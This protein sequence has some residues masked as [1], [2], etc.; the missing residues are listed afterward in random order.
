MKLQ[1]EQ[2]ARGTYQKPGTLTINPSRR[3]LAEEQTVKVTGNKSTVTYNGKEQSLDGFTTNR[4]D[5]TVSLAEGK[6]AVAKGTDAGTYQM[7]LTAD[8]FTATSANYTNITVEVEDG[9][10]KID[11]SAEEQTVKVTGNKS[12]VTYNGKEQSLDGFTT[13]RSDITVSLAEGKE[14]VAK[15]TDAGTYQM[16]LTA[17]S[18]TATSANYTNITVEVEDGWL[19]IDPSA[20]EQTVKVTGNKSTVTYNGKEQSLDGLQQIEAISQF[21]WQKA[22]K[23]NIPDGSDSRQLYSNIC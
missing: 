20:E 21:R 2:K 15:G 10:L 13:N 1:S 12:T 9:W 5:I 3:W 18:F 17:D 11:P 7:G 16:G 14:A 23:P 19:K 8:S 6:E 4:S 22:R